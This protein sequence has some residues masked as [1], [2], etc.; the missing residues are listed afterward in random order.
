VLAEHKDLQRKRRRQRA[1]A[2]ALVETLDKMVLQ[3]LQTQAVVVVVVR[4]VLAPQEL[5]VL[6]VAAL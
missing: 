6:A 4:L 2:V 3:A 1:V 5:A